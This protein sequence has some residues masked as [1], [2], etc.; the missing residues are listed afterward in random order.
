M[1][2]KLLDIGILSFSSYKLVRI[3]PVLWNA[4]D[5]FLTSFTKILNLQPRV[6]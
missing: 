5:L 4:T 6:Y 2:A 1:G 3:H